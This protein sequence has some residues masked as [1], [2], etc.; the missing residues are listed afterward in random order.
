MFV[1]NA[2]RQTRGMDGRAGLMSEHLAREGRREGGREG[3][4]EGR[5]EGGTCSLPSLLTPHRHPLRR[6]RRVQGRRG[7]G[8]GCRSTNI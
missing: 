2:S 1:S 8:G 4:R 5:R 6:R 7:G 3:G